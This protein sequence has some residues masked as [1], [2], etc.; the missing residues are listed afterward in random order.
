MKEAWTIPVALLAAACGGGG[1][2]SNSLLV[3]SDGPEGGS[4]VAGD[5]SAPGALDAS[6]E[7]GGVQVHL[8]A[9]GC[10]G[11]CANVKAVATGGHPPYTFVWENGSTDPARSVCP[12]VNST[13]SVTVTDTGSSGELAQAPQTARASLAADVQLCPDGGAPPGDASVIGEVTVPGISDIWLA[14]QPDGSS[15]K[16]AD[17]GMDVVP[18]NSPVEV[19]VPAGRTLMFSATGSTSYTG[20]ICSAASPD[21]GCTVL[22]TSQG[23]ANG[24]ASITVAY[25]ALV[26]VFLGPSAPS[27][28]PPAGLDFTGNAST[29]T[30]LSP[31]IGQ[32]FFIGD[33]LTGSGSGS[34]QQFVVPA[35]ATRLFLASSDELGGSYNNSGQFDVVVSSL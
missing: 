13:Y 5:A 24:I 33:G 28:S 30:T 18:T 7:R 8:V 23:P 20:G 4:F 21:G 29:F 16:P 19:P 22:V 32:V 25:D 34:V 9:L 31:A 27:G 26:G 15:L 14:G 17:Y 10:S 12:T 11:A 6:I 35:G 3:G 1:A 2:P